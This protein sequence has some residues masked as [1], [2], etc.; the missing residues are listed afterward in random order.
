MIE[1][2]KLNV[3][4]KI[5]LLSVL[6]ILGFLLS[7]KKNQLGGKSTI[8]GKVMHHTRAIANA[9]VFIKFNA[10]EFPGADTNAY[11]AKVRADGNG[12]Y[13]IKCY[14]GDY[15]LFGFGFDY[16]IPAPYIVEGGLHVNIRNNETVTT[17]VPIT[18]P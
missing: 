16:S 3:M 18:E 13:T 10:K 4:K 8:T 17:D 11:D 1:S 14:K 2:L 6:A 9:A 5:F 12:T 15:F 7:C